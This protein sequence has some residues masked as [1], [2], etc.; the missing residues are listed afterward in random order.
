VLS[1]L[2]AVAA[3]RG[4]AAVLADLAR[5]ATLDAVKDAAPAGALVQVIATR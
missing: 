4:C 5:G 1:N 3:G 2:V